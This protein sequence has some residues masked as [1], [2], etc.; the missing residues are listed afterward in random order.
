ML[1]IHHALVHGLADEVREV[2]HSSSS[3]RNQ[4]RGQITDARWQIWKRSELQPRDG[5]NAI[6]SAA[7]AP[8]HLCTCLCNDGRN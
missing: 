1:S 7:H 8:V 4:M 6:L 3:G 2:L 5:R